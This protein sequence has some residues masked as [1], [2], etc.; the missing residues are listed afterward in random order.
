MTIANTITNISYTGTTQKGN[1]AATYGIPV[2]A[3]IWGAGGGSS[4]LYPG[5]GGGYSRVQFVAKPGDDL[6][7]AVGQGGGAG[8]VTA[9]PPA[10]PVTFN[11]R[12][13]G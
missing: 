10:P 9:P 4:S 1:V 8:G 2:T 12:E 13:S 7:V 5:A 3:H 6:L 11:T